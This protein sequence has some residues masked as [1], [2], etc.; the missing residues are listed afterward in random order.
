MK[1]TRAGTTPSAKG[2][3]DYFTGTVRLDKFVSPPKPPAG[4]R[5]RR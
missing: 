5:A 2:P 3:S 1:I 4:C